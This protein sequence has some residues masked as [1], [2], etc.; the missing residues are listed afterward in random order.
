MSSLEGSAR[1]VMLEVLRHGPTSRADLARRL[2]LSSASLTRLTK[3]LVVG[4]LLRERS[5]EL[6]SSTGRPSLPLEVVAEAAY[7]VG[8]KIVKDAIFSVVTDFAGNVVMRREAPVHDRSVDSVLRVVEAEVRR[9]KRAQPRIAAV[10]VTV[11]GMVSEHSTVWGV[12]SL[13]WQTVDLGELLRRRLQLPVTVEND[14]KAFAQAEHWFG[15]GR[16]LRSFA[17]ITV[18]IGVGA[19]FIAN[20]ELVTGHQG[21]AGLLDHWPLD[22]TGPECELCGHPGCVRVSLSS[23]SLERRASAE[24]GRT[25][26]FDEL[27]DLAGAGDPAADRMARAAAHQL[28]R[29]TALVANMVGPERVLLS[30]DGIGYAL[31]AEPELRRGLTEARHPGAPAD[32]LVIEP[33]EFFEW[34]RGAAA[35]AIREHILH[36]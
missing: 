6:L 30:G 14:V 23:P 17:V 20:D 28:G 15:A 25:V 10:G 8:V 33:L 21:L 27:M 24:L 4:G 9:L 36:R 1:A 7:F 5:A 35:M 22:P 3:P 2:N 34:A 19:A 29:F 12:S 13:G 16:G 11:G 32:D 26:S 18:G 31:L